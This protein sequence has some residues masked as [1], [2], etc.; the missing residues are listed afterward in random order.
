MTK[1]EN[2]RPSQRIA[3][4]FVL[5][6]FRSA[7]IKCAEDHL[8]FRCNVP[9]NKHQV[10]P[11]EFKPLQFPAARHEIEKLRAIS[12]T[13][14]TLRSNHARRQAICKVFETVARK[15]VAGSKG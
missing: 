15:N 2:S 8:L 7:F 6:H 14:E 10:G 9:S 11:I 12:K 4:S 1:S 5:R 13:D 3:S